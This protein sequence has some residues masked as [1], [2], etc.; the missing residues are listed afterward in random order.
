MMRDLNFFS[1]YQVPPAKTSSTKLLAITISVLAAAVMLFALA[2][3][4]FENS[5]LE[6]EISDAEITLN[7]PEISQKLKEVEEIEKGIATVKNDQIV[8]TNLEGDFNKLHRV[9]KAFMNF[10]QSRLTRNVVFDKIDI[11][12][13]KVQIHGISTER[14]SIAKF[15][16]ELRKSEKFNHILVSTITKRDPEEDRGEEDVYEFLME[17]ET[18]DVDFNE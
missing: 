13:D 12:H 11:Q 16:E 6:S 18:K 1:K 7:S 8:F 17:I 9:N 3:Y 15:E 10:V 2:Y 4:F 5:R 14:L